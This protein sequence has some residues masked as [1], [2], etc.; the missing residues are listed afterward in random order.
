MCD[1]Q[2]IIG[3]WINFGQRNTKFFDDNVE[4]WRSFCADDF[5]RQHNTIAWEILTNGTRNR[6]LSS[7]IDT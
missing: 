4:L 6:L 1:I 3:V 5:L 2:E 7:E